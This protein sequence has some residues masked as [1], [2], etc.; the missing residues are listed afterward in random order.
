MIVD[1]V[2]AFIVLLFEQRI[3]TSFVVNEIKGCD[4]DVVRYM[5]RGGKEV[6][7]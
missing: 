3:A 2:R 7:G 4:M 1:L 6:L 5:T